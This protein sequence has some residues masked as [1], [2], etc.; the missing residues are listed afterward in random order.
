MKGHEIECALN[1]RTT[2]PQWCRD[3]IANPPRSGEG[4]HNWMFR[5]ARGL[6]KCG[7]HGN[8]IR[9]LL[10]NAAAACGRHVS[11]REIL[12]AVRHSQTSAF[13]LTRA[14]HR[15]WTAVNHEQREGV[16]ATGLGLVDLWEISPV[17]F[18]DNESHTEELIDR[19]F[20]G[21]P[22]LC[23][24]AAPHDC[25]TAT[26]DEWR[27]RLEG[28]PLIVP[29]PMTA[30][31]GH[32]QNGEVSN[33]CLE[34]TGTRRF[35]IAEFDTGTPDEHAALLFHLAKRAPLALAVHS[36]S[37]SLHGWFYCAG[38]AEEKVLRFFRY[39]VSLGADRALW[40]RCQLVRM[41]D[42][43]RNNGN[44]QTVYFF[45]PEVIR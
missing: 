38:A 30:V 15:P 24:G 39:A 14:R 4:F 1:Q 37:K 41:P 34:N 12:D 2:L 31:A 22:L 5:A 28:L 18:A 44:K 29:S 8:D 40:T 6:W 21:N 16:I 25:R 7:R 42:G 36:G 32:N 26:R 33:R 13:Q 27:G 11:E 35:L 45:N 19:L 17:R 23:V 20:P 43:T 9:E 10:Q 3:I